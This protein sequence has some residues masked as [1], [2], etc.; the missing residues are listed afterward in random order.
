MYCPAGLVPG[1]KVPF[2]APP[3]PLH[4]PPDAG[5][6]PSEPNRLKGAAL[7][8]T[9]TVL[10]VPAFGGATSCTITEAVALAHGG[11]PATVY[12][13]TSGTSVSGS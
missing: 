2:I 8:H 11:S 9:V 13:Y 4:V 10:S 7:L 5:V 6:P 1:V 12:V 3:G